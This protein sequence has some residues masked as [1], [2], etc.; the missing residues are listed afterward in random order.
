[1]TAVLTSWPSP[2][3]LLASIG[4]ASTASNLALAQAQL[5]LVVEF[6]RS[7]TRGAGFDPDSGAT[8]IV[9]DLKAVILSA[10]ARAIANPTQAKRLEI[11]GVNAVPAIF[12]GFTLHEQKILNKYRVTVN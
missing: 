4:W 1:M 12:D 11:G 2:S 7:F 6:V 10:A 3:D 9:P 8:F 5:D